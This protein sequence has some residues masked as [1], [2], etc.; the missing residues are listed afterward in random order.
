MP[1]YVEEHVKK[2]YGIPRKLFDG[3]CQIHVSGKIR[4]SNV[5]LFAE[6]RRFRSDYTQP[7]RTLTRKKEAHILTINVIIPFE[8]KQG[9]VESGQ[10][11]WAAVTFRNYRTIAPWRAQY[12]AIWTS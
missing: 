1:P 8:I 5:D 2:E 3:L 6:M 7:T 11:G 10:R 4:V 12:S 9:F